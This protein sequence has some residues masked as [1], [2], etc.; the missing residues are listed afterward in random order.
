MLSVALKSDAPWNE[1]H[2]RNETFDKMLVE[3]R[4]LLDTEKRRELY[5]E[6]QRMI[7]EE[8]G[9]IIPVFPSVIDAYNEEV[10][11]VVEDHN[12]GLMGIASRRESLACLVSPCCRLH[13][14]PALSYRLAPMD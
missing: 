11:G 9:Y 13:L 10:Q 3:A 6:M 1:T 2:F 4:G 12:W 14:P 8:G 5:W 7:S